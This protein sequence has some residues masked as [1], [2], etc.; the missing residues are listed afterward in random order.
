MAAEAVWLF[1]AVA[2][3]KSDDF[4]RTDVMVVPY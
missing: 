4:G 1:G 3:L 2:V